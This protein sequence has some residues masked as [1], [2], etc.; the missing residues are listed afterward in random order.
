MLIEPKQRSLP[1]CWEETELGEIL[2]LKNGFA[3]KS[4]SYQNVGTPVIRISDIQ[5]GVVTTEFSVRIIGSEEFNNYSVNKGDILMAMS[6]ATTGK[7]GIYKANE[8]AFQNQRV[9]NFRLYSDELVDKKFIFSLL[10]NLKRE[11]EKKA[12]GGAQPNISAKNIENLKFNLP[13]LPEQNQ[14]VAKISN[15]TCRKIVMMGGTLLLPLISRPTPCRPKTQT[16]K[17]IQ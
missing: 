12:Y 2:F 13:P 6:G 8:S 10:G 4:N 9:G 3:F 15:T 14:I 11:I 7:F 1:I 5:N 17:T 16:N